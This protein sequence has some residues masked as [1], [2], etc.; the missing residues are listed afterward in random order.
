GASGPARRPHR[1]GHDRD[2]ADGDRGPYPL[3]PAWP[4][5]RDL[6]PPAGT[7]RVRSDSVSVHAPLV[8]ASVSSAVAEDLRADRPLLVARTVARAA[9]KLAITRG[10]EDE[11][12]EKDDAAADLFAV[13]GNV[14]FAV[15][16][17]A[18]TRSW[19][20]L[21]G[22]VEIGRVRVP[23]GASTIEVQAAG[24]SMTVPVD[25]PGG[26]IRIEHVRLP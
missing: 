18:D 26:S 16:E 17:Q 1:H 25:A 5:F 22:A 2:D 9:A 4:V 24:R 23:S 8:R 14:A 15:T 7:A 13:L 20:L 3:R 6:A 11:I 21:P 10:I 19:T 12:R